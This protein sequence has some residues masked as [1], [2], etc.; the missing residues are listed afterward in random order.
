MELKFNVDALKAFVGE[1]KSKERKE[2]QKKSGISKQQL[3]MYLNNGCLPG[4]QTFF[5]I[6][7]ATGKEPSH[8]IIDDSKAE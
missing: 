6:C 3:F 4:M 8:F 7:K 5:R 2:F 1:D